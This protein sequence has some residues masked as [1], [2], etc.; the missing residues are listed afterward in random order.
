MEVS[1]AIPLL[2]LVVVG[3]RRFVSM[4]RGI[5]AAGIA[6]PSSSVV[7]RIDLIAQSFP[8]TASTVPPQ[9]GHC[10]VG[11]GPTERASSQY[12]GRPRYEH[13]SHRTTASTVS[14]SKVESSIGVCWVIAM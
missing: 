13:S 7:N 2:G 10:R 8:S 14:I 11:I 4:R 3:H 9:F 1:G 5:H 12:F 6:N